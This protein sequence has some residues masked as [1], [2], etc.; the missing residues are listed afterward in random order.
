M[1]HI[2]ETIRKH[3]NET[4]AVGR[5]VLAYGELEFALCL[6]LATALD[7]DTEE[8]RLIRAGRVLYRCRGEEMRIV[9][10]DALMRAKFASAGL[11]DPYTES[12][13]DLRYCKKI[14]NRYAHCHW[15]TDDQHGLCFL[16]IEEGAS[17]ADFSMLTRVLDMALIAEQQRYYSNVHDR[18]R[19]LR[20]SLDCHLDRRDRPTS[21]P[22]RVPR[23]SLCLAEID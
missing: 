2:T 23:P 16:S 21:L 13:G 8:E 20:E 18:L 7:D 10:A 3:P 11:E 1:Y 19:A 17:H 9:V 15:T 6:C 22:T 14:R 5:L 12:I 4:A